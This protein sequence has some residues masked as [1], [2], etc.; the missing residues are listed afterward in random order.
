MSKYR[1]E[2]GGVIR[3]TEIDFP[4]HTDEIIELLEEKDQQISDLEAKLAECEKSKESYRLQ[5]EHHHLQLLQFY[6]RLGV[7]AFGADIHEKAL[8]TLMI[9]KEELEEK[10]GVERALSACNRQNDEFS[11]MIKKLVNEKEELKQQLAEKDKQIADLQHRLEVAEKVSKFACDELRN[12][13][14]RTFDNA[15]IDF[16]QQFKEQSEKELKGEQK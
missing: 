10:N 12:L 3:D 15:D 13:N 14:Y 5:N 16:E 8:E 6:S 1:Y 2:I 7:E 9:M 11:D 4:Y